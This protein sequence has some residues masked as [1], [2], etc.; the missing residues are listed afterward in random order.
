MS[1]KTNP[2]HD[3]VLARG[4]LTAHRWLILRRAS[5]VGFLGLFLIG[6]L[7]GYYLIKGQISSSLTLD[8]LPLTDPYILLQTF[9]AGHVPEMTA[10]VG[11]LIVTAVYLLLGGRTYC[12][13]V[14]P[15]NIITDAAHWT[16]ARLGIQGGV[17]FSNSVRYWMLAMTLGVAFA[18]GVLAWELVNPVTMIYRGIVFGAGWFWGVVIALFLF[19]LLISERGWCSHL[20]PVGAFY[21][22]LGKAAVLRISAVRREDCNDCMDCYA[23]CPEQQVISPALKGA[24]QNASPV[25]HAGACTNCGRCIDVCALN[26]FEFGS[27]FGGPIIANSQSKADLKLKKVA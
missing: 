6:P 20:C 23:V 12:S 5:Q 24:K 21:G 26:V 9:A 14:C 2:G 10:I 17:K 4:W 15:V 16:R 22:T 18:T 25:I 1:A 8:V 7:S 27:R 19:D 3:S 11:A 13:W